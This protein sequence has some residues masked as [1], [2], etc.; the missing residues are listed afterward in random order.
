M[1]RIHAQHLGH[2]D[3]L[4][5][6]VYHTVTASLLQVNSRILSLRVRFKLGFARVRVLRIVS[7]V[8]ALVRK[9]VFH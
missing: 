4:L 2:L 8:V 9:E 1:F 6:S 5:R 3:Y 7:L